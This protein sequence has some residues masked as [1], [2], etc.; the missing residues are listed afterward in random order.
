METLQKYIDKLNKLNFKEMYN[1]GFFLT[2]EKTDD[3]IEAVFTV[4]DALRY[5]RENN[6]STKVFESGLGI[7]LF[8]DNSTR[9]RFSFASACNLLGLEVQDLDEGKSQVAHGETVRETANM[10][11]DA[12]RGYRRVVA[13]P[14]PAEI[15]EIG[16]I[17]TM[18]DAGNLVIACGGGGIPVIEQKHA[19][20]GAS[21]VIEKD[22]IAGKLAADLM[23]DQLIILTSVPNVYRN[24]GTQ[25]QEAILR[26]SLSEA[27]EMIREDQFEKGTMLPKIEAAISYLSVNKGGSALVTSINAIGPALK[28]KAGT[29]ITI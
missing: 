21:A 15:I 4:A 1:G 6:I 14:K 16:T 5:M 3:E 18:V 24:F 12:G 28:G 7:S 22:A 19:L 20:K 17:R 11:E 8:R 9:T 27:E 13:S 23:A 2:W 29:L 10:K 26:L 25:E